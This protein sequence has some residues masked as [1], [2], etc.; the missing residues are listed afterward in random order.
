M[1]NAEYT[2]IIEKSP[3]GGYWAF[4][5]EVSGANGQGET[6]EETKE[7]LKNAI[8]LILM[9]RVEDYSR[10]LSP[11]VLVEKVRIAS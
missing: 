8:E 1:M 7:S 2:A 6:V 3:E 9:D 10:G 5:P 11:D 4:C